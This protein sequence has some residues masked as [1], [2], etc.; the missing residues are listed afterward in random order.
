VTEFV[1]DLI[2]ERPL[3]VNAVAS[4]HRQQWATRTR[5][6]RRAWELLARAEKVPAMDRIRVVVTPLHKDRRSPQDCAACAPAVKAAVDGLV[7]AGVI[8]DDNPDHLD[9]ITFR[10]PWVC[11]ADGLRL[12]IVEVLAKEAA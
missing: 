12:R 8:P 4:L 11:G 7:D 1:L 5:S 9:E 10:A 3:T 6:E 2:G